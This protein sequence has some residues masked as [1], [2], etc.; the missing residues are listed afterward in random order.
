M[1]FVQNEDEFFSGHTMSQVFLKLNANKWS[2]N[3][4]PLYQLSSS[5]SFF[6]QESFREIKE[7]FYDLSWKRKEES[8]YRQYECFLSP[9]EESVMRQFYSSEFFDPLKKTLER[10][11]NVKF[12]DKMLVVAHRLVSSDVIGMHNDY[13]HPELGNE[14]YRLIVQFSDR[15]DS[16]TGGDLTFYACKY[17]KIIHQV[18]NL[19]KNTAVV[20]QI[21]P[22]S[23]HSVS[24]VDGERFSLVFYFWLEG[25][26]T[27]GKAYEIFSNLN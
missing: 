24:A 12:Q 15:E 20:F 8:F 21:T 19:T 16:V 2:H 23:Y 11:L 13:S 6:D 25:K 27:N 5:S 3:F 18:Y 22:E 10:E 17:T 4:H 26:K 1:H 14:N 7:A 9:I